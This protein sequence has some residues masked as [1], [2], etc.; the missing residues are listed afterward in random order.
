M[1]QFLIARNMPITGQIL[2]QSFYQI[3]VYKVVTRIRCIETA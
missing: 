1:I 2:Y 3:Q